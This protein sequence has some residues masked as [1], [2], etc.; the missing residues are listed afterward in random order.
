VTKTPAD[1]DLA[2]AGLAQADEENAK[3]AEETKLRMRDSHI[4]DR[5]CRLDRT[6]H[7]TVFGPVMITTDCRVPPNAWVVPGTFGGP[8]TC[9]DADP[10]DA[11]P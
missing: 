7:E 8:H 3:L 11:R 6:V 4:C 2:L 9:T 5:T 10:C 1:E